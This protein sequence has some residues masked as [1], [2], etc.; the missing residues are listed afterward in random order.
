MKTFRGTFKN[1]KRWRE[2]LRYETGMAI[3]AALVF[4]VLGCIPLVVTL[5]MFVDTKEG[6]RLLISGYF[7]FALSVF[8]YNVIK[9]LWECFQEE[10]EH[11]FDTL[12]E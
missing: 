1:F 8:M 6:A 9:T 2:M 7:I 3:M 4:T 10:R 5:I 11:V 12:R